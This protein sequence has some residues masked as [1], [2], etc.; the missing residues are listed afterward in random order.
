LGL[1]ILDAATDFFITPSRPTPE[2]MHI[3]REA[4]EEAAEATSAQAKTRAEQDR[5]R[6]IE[7]YVRQMKEAEEQYKR[8]ERDRGR[9]RD[10]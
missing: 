10:R 1:K 9:T 4:R 5:Q 8:L 2:M 3:R 7:E 6:Q